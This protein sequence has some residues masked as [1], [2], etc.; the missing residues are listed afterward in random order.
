[1]APFVDDAWFVTASHLPVVNQPLNY[2]LPCWAS[3][4]R[5]VVAHHATSQLNN[6]AL[7]PEPFVTLTERFCKRKCPPHLP[8]FDAETFAIWVARLRMPLLWKI[9]PLPERISQGALVRRS[10]RLLALVKQSADCLNEQSN[11]LW[12][13]QKCVRASL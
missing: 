10:I 6:V 8:D 5:I 1:M 9:S 13:A 3:A 4:W 2:L 12:C 11:A 7:P